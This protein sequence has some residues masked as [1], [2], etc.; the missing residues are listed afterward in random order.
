MDEKEKDE[1]SPEYIRGFNDGYLIAKHD[2]ELSKQLKDLDADSTRMQGFQDGMREITKEKTQNIYP[3][4]LQ[5]K[6]QLGIQKNDPV[7][8]KDI[9]KE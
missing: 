3:K 5:N 2:P 8:D 9:D 1:I 6:S 4:W 7:K